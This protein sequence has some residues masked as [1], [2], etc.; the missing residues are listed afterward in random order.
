M[1]SKP[2]ISVCIS[3][4]NEDNYLQQCID[5]LMNQTMHNGIEY[6]FVN[7]ASTDDSEEILL[8]N[9][10]KYS[11]RIRVIKHNEHLG[12][13]EARNTALNVAQGE[14]VGFVDSD[15]FVSPWMFDFLYNNA[16]LSGADVV[17]IQYVSIPQ[18][19]KYDISRIKLLASHVPIVTWSQNLL[20]WN[21]Q[22]LSDKA[23]SDILAY[24]IGGLYCGL[25]KKSFL[26]STSVV[27]PAPRYEDNYYGSLVKCYLKRIVF[28]PRVCYFYRNNPAS[29]THKRNAPHQLDRIWI[30]KELL[31]EVKKRDL[32]EKHYAA[33]E[34]IYT[35]RYAY[36]TSIKLLT[37]YD[38]PPITIIKKIWNDLEK[39][40]PHWQNNEYY[41]ELVDNRERFKYF[42]LKTCPKL[43]RV[44][45]P[46]FKGVY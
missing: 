3:V 25:W 36:N 46:F 22:N 42:L 31:A 16:T 1:N 34:Y 17:F 2:K 24:P 9:A 6:I 44:L 28:V 27:F 14:Y 39:E 26:K 45:Y 41:C 30:E 18:N 19:E 43:V 38:N 20:R 33:W 35:F 29:I 21:N 15:D 5:S 13:G 32:F 8:Y 7:D 37:T 4:F 40:F 23:I 12:L 10:R 11:D